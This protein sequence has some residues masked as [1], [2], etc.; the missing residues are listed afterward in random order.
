MLHAIVDAGVVLAN[1]MVPLSLKTN[2]R[3]FF[4]QD[5]EWEATRGVNTLAR[6]NRPE[7]ST[8]ATAKPESA[9][10]CG[11]IKPSTIS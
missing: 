1:L 2:Y 11:G 6:R 7:N 3:A 9:L 10:A 5:S 8:Q 4:K